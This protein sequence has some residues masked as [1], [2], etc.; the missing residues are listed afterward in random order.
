MI[1]LFSQNEIEMRVYGDCIIVDSKYKLMNCKFVP[2]DS[3]FK[4]PS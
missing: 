1:A 4:F 3:L 2:V